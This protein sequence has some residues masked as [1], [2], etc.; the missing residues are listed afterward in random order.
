MIVVIDASTT[1]CSVALVVDHKVL[2]SLTS[3]KDRSSAENLTL[4]I[5]E[6]LRLGGATYQDLKAVAVAQGPGSYTGLRIA[7]STAKG[8]AYGLSLP[9]ISYGTL[10]SLCYQVPY[11]DGIDLF[12]PMID[13]RRMEVFCGFY[14]SITVEEVFPVEAVLVDNQS[15]QSI[16]DS[17][18]VLFLGEGSGKCRDVIHH[19]N[20]VFLNT[21]LYPV[22]EF[23]CKV[24]SEKFE[25]GFFEDLVTFEPFYLK[26]YMFKT[27]SL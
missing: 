25:K 27:K 10:P 23:A 20:A 14:N 21:E 22:A 4:M 1:G 13:A 9:L 15:F 2:A 11:A 7:V 16:L 12:C 17:N 5:G 6:V 18:K 19:P 3:R 8:L 26:E 24:V